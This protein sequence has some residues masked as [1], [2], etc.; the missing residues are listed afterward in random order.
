MRPLPFIIGT[1]EWAAS[2]T[3]GL[4]EPTASVSEV[5]L[6]PLFTAF[7]VDSCYLHQEISLA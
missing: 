5:L 1:E 3:A 7:E 6:K 4:Y 2:P